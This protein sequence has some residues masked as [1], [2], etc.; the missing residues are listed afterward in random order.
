MTMRSW[1]RQLFA[2]PRRPICRAPVRPRLEA[3]ED[4]L[5]P[6]AYHVTSLL[7]DGSAGTLRAAI[8]QANANPG[9]DTIDFALTG[10]ITLNSTQLPTITDDL[11]VSGPGAAS[12]TL[13][14]HGASRVLQV[15]AGATVGLSGLTIANASAPGGLSGYYSAYRG[16]AIF[17]RG[18]LTL[19]DS[20]LAG[21]HDANVGGGITNF[22][23]T[24]VLTNSTVIGNSAAGT[25]GILNWRGTL[26]VTDSTI[27]GNTATVGVRDYG[28][29]GGGISNYIGTMA[30]TDSTLSGN[31]SL[32]GGGI[33]TYRGRLTLT[34]STLSGK[35][36]RRHGRRHPHLR[37]HGGGGQLHSL[38]KQGALRRR[39]PIRDG[40]RRHLESH[41]RRQCRQPDG[42]QQH[43][44]RQLGG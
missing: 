31:S 23:G 17:N 13:D 42:D 27:S 25:G 12:L 22:L 20:T 21:N 28:K 19:R 3:L 2:R 44:V 29:N 8:T 39:R 10:T 40:R 30:V 15:G 1:I 32:F 34:N 7:D 16:G 9:A 36:R 41:F 11:T 14:A 5:A 38:R 37:Q 43:P 6:A 4:R 26:E 35:H 24:V 33:D 18:T